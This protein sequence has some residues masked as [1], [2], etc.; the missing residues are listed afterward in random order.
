MKKMLNCLLAVACG[1]ALAFEPKFEG[2]K[3]VFE[4]PAA[5]TFRLECQT[6]KVKL[7]AAEGA[8]DFAVAEA[9]SNQML[10]SMLVPP[11]FIQGGT[12]RV[13]DKEGAFPFALGLDEDCREGRQ[14]RDTGA[15]LP[16]GHLLRGAGQPQVELE[17]V[18]V[19][20]LPAGGHEG[21]ADDVCIHAG[22]G[23]EETA[24]Q[25]RADGA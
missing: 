23:A 7:S 10:L 2:G 3:V 8:V 15:L 5:G 1:S 17:H 21:V 14:W 13:D 4:C 9:K 18:R 6:G 22:E 11:S 24:G 12:W 19:P 20:H 25:I 16:R